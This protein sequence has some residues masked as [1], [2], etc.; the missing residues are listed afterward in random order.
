MFQFQATIRGDV[1]P[2]IPLTA[3]SHNQWRRFQSAPLRVLAVAPLALTLVSIRAGSLSAES[4]LLILICFVKGGVASAA[5]SDWTFGRHANDPVRTQPPAIR[6]DLGP[7]GMSI[8][9]ARGHFSITLLKLSAQV[10]VYSSMVSTSLAIYLV[11]WGQ[12]TWF[13]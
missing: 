3:D 8:S 4:F 1:S 10:V 5:L 12:V 6:L 7:P 13:T 9:M 2:I 11:S